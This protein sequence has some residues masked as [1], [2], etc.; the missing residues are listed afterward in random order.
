MVSLVTLLAMPLLVA[1]V[2]SVLVSLAVCLHDV[3]RRRHVIPSLH[4][5]ESSLNARLLARC[6]LRNRVFSPSAWLTSSHVQ[7]LAAAIL[8]RGDGSSEVSF[9]REYLQ[10]RDKGVVALD[11][12]QSVEPR[13]K[14]KSTV[15]LVLP[16]VTG[17]A[18]TVS[19]LCCLATSRGFRTLVFNRRGHGGSVLTTP[20]LQSSADPSDLRQVVKYLRLRFPKSRLA[21]VGYGTGCGLLI[22]YL[23]EF[24]SSAILCAGACVSPCYDTVERFSGSLRGMYDLVYLLKL[25]AVVLRHARAL[26]AVLDIP[27][28]MT[29]WSFRAFEERVYC[30]MYNYT[31]HTPPSAPS[32]TNSASA[33]STANGQPAGGSST[34]G[35]TTSQSRSQN[36]SQSDSQ[37]KSQSHSPS[38]SYS[39]SQSQ[40]HSPSQSQSHSP[41]Q[42]QSHS[43]SQSQSHSPSQSQSHSPSQSQ[44]HSPSQP[45]PPP[46]PAPQGSV[47][48][49]WERNNPFRDVDDIAVPVLCINAL[50]DPLCDAAAIPYDLFRCYPHFLLVVT[51]R[52][53]HCGFLER[54]PFRSWADCLCLDYLEAVFEVTTRGYVTSSSA[55]GHAPPTITRKHARSTI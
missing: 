10:M 36:L 54:F 40:S 16:P 33:A 24:G 28:A 52:G 19:S 34:S 45:P 7:T 42:S 21:A 51:D 35:S 3:I 5:R 22:S 49:Y 50:D 18:F 55:S 41:S 9:Q 2:W 14:R 48:E 17:T 23:G 27:Q 11:W 44:S 13:V 30:K 31:V 26:S 38:Q 15:L 8:P 29:A 43:P 1:T 39:P 37:S 20:K 53:G 6:G 12:V 47:E 25:K 4:Y 46:S 32:A